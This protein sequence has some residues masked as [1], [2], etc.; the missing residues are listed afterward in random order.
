MTPSSAALERAR[1]RLVA[2]GLRAHL[3]IR[4]AWEE[5]DRQVDGLFMGFWLSHVP[6]TR[7]ADFL[8]LSRRWL[9]PAGRLA[10][11]DSLADPAS[12]RGRPSDAR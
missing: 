8:T 12:R 1:D 7:L 3:H 4:D 2:H 5:P 9:K 6:R 10:F 11:I